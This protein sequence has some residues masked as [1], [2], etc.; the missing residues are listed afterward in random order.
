M[1]KKITGYFFSV[2]LLVASL[3][4]SGIGQQI[5]QVNTNPIMA[6]TDIPTA[7]AGGPYQGKTNIAIEFDGSNSLDPDNNIISYTWY[8]GDGLIETGMRT[9]HV[10]KYPGTYTL[11]LKVIDADNHCSTDATKV[12]I[13]ADDKPT[14]SFIH[15]YEHAIF[16]RNTYLIPINGTTILIGPCN[17][18]I[19]AED[20]IGIQKV[21]I[22]IDDQIKHSDTNEPY[23]Y[24][25]KN[26]LFQHTITAT[27]IDTSGQSNN[28]TLQVFKWN[29]HPL[30]LLL[31]LSKFNDD[32]NNYFDWI[33]NDHIFF[34][35]I[36]N[37]FLQEN[38]D[39][40]DNTILD[41]IKQLKETNDINTFDTILHFLDNHPL[42]K[43]KF[44]EKYPFL[45][46]YLHLKSSSFYS[47]NNNFESD[48]SLLKIIRNLIIFTL[49]KN[50]VKKS[51]EA[52]SSP[53]LSNFELIPWM[54]DH[55]LLSIT[56]IILL[57]ILIQRKTSSYERDVPTEPEN[58]IPHA[59]ITCPSE[60]VV[61][62]IITFS[63][64]NSYDEDGAIVD[65]IWD[66]GDGTSSTGKTVTHKYEEP[67]MYL[68]KLTVIDSDQETAEDSF[69]I[70]IV[71]SA[72]E[73]KESE[74]TDDGIQFW[75]VSGILAIILLIGMILL[76]FRRKIFE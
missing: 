52:D 61:Y 8:C 9:N 21:E 27:A 5:Q 42:L 53:L 47:T 20:D 49:I 54:Q 75:L 48:N 68:V 60:S 44:T 7:D 64:E 35:I 16:F 28:V 43:N 6:S 37:I 32:E 72:D 46:L 3:S 4:A 18:T 65:F 12:T 56:G 23:S 51:I 40:S 15:P 24:L 71:S 19:N 69:Q 29:I 58:R 38:T 41:L 67:G 70:N 26:G 39:I 11:L 30:L 34:D 55:P 73:L 66:F 45:Y 25:W 33:T 17:I 31:L 22:S 13:I 1:L 14:L 62:D 2:I 59:I 57:M 63:A 36:K 10:Y 74:T 76:L 50:K